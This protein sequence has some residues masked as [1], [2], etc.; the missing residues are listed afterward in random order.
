MSLNGIKL[1]ASLGL[2]IFVSSR[3]CAQDKLA[4]TNAANTASV[5][6]VAPAILPGKGLAEHDFFYAGESRAERMY[7]VRDGKIVW[8]YT[9]PGRGEISDATLLSNGNILF[10]HQFGVTEITADKK[11]VWNYDAPTNTEIHTAQAIGKDRVWFIENGNPAKFMLVNKVT[12]KTE[13][14]FVLPALIPTSIHGQFRQARLTDAGTL[15]VAHMDLGLVCEYKAD[16]KALWFADVP[17]AWSV[18]PLKN[19]NVLVGSNKNFVREINRKGETVWEWTPADAPGYKFS[20][21]QT[22]TRLENGNTLINNWFTGRINPDNAPVQAVEV[23]PDKKIVWALRS[24]AEPADL[25]PSTII[26]VLD[27]PGV[28][29]NVRFGDIH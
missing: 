22:A 5:A 21:L 17:G 13:K 16:G 20:S 26:Q 4:T 27:K 18:M 8:S 1:C 7:I 24:W 28:P 25:G 15:L 11:V 9:H 29:E 3:A 12:G 2:I 23:T 10:A 6:P 19:G 14:E